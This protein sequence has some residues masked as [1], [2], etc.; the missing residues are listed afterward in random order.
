MIAQ[1]CSH[2]TFSWKIAY[3]MNF[4][5]IG[6]EWNKIKEKYVAWHW[7]NGHTHVSAMNVLKM[8][9]SIRTFLCSVTVDS[10]FYIINKR[11]LEINFEAWWILM[12]L[13][14]RSKAWFSI[15]Y[16]LRIMLQS[17]RRFYSRIFQLQLL[18]WYLRSV[19]GNL[20]AA[21]Y[22]KTQRNYVG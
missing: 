4:T 3:Q 6:Y 18:M 15:M 16:R 22:D 10:S 7:P 13:N 17:L 8:T 19:L 14:K 5:H 21:Y 11:G 1:K 9:K 12:T 2:I 20:I